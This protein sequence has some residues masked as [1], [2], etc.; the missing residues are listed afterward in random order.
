MRSLWE[1]QSKKRKKPLQ[2]LFLVMVED[3]QGGPYH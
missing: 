1:R 3:G 2:R